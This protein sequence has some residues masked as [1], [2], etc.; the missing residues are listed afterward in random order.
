MCCKWRK[1]AFS[2]LTRDEADSL[3]NYAITHGINRGKWLRPFPYGDDAADMDE[4]RVRL[5]SPVEA[6]RDALRRAKTAGDSVEAIFRFLE[7]TNAY[8]RLMA[9]E[10]ALLSR[11]MAAEATQNRQV[12][13]ILMTLL[14]QLY[15]LLSTQKGKSAGFGTV[16]GI[17]FDRRVDFVPAAAAGHGDDRRSGAFDDRAD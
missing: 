6:L 9:R 10:E 14:D 5:I 13:T 15:A 3:E 7:D 8:D 17:R 11:G 1:A 16:R 2:S 12:W 4:L